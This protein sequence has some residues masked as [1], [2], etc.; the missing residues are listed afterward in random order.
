MAT[1]PD[2]S[3]TNSS[4]SSTLN[5]EIKRGRFSDSQVIFKYLK[6]SDSSRLATFKYEAEVL[7]EL[8]DSNLFPKFIS[9]EEQDGMPCL[10]M[11]DIFAESLRSIVDS[12]RL[13]LEAAI[14]AGWQTAL[15][16]GEL[17][18]RK[19]VHKDINPSNIIANFKER[20]VQVIDFG[21]STKV[22]KTEDY[23]DLSEEFA[24]TISY[25]SPEQTGRVNSRV[26]Y[27]SDF[28][29]LGVTLYELLTGTLPFDGENHSKTIYKII[30][31]SPKPPR[32]INPSIP[33][34][35]SELVM[36]LLE[37]D[38]D[39]RYQTAAGIA[40]DLE[41]IHQSI[42][43]G[44][45]LSS[46]CLKMKD[47]Q[48]KFVYP[49]KLYGREKEIGIIKEEFQ[50][51]CNGE[52]SLVQ[53]AGHSGIG[54]SAIVDYLKPMIFRSNCHFGRGKF[55]QYKKNIP[56][57][58]LAESMI[59]VIHG[60]LKGNKEYYSVVKAQLKSMSR[61]NSTIL[62]DVI[63]DFS[64]LLDDELE[65]VEL[66]FDFTEYSERLKFA[67]NQFLKILCDGNTPVVL[68]IDDVQ[69]ADSGSLELM[70]S[71]IQ[72]DS[73]GSLLVI[74]AY[75][76]NEMYPSHK[77]AMSINVLEKK[78]SDKI[79][80]L[81][82]EGISQTA[83]GDLVADVLHCD[84]S[85]V[86]GMSKIIHQKTGGNP[87]YIKTL[88]EYLHDEAIF[89]F[90]YSEQKWEWDF[91]DVENAQ[92]TDNV[93]DLLL[94][95][96]KG[97]TVETQSLLK[98]ASCMG[99]KFDY[100]TLSILSGLSDQQLYQNL[101]PAL[102]GGM[103]YPLDGEF[104]VFLNDDFRKD[105][106]FKFRFAHDKVQQASYELVD[107][108]ERQNYHYIIAK[109]LLSSFEGDEI[110]DYIF[111]IAGHLN[112]GSVHF[113]SDDFLEAV[114]LNYKA[115]EIAF[116][117][118]S[119][120]SSEHY[121]SKAKEYLPSISEKERK[122]ELEFEISKLLISCQYSN[123][124]YDNCI[125]NIS[126]L[127]SKCPNNV[128]LADLLNIEGK[129]YYDTFD[130]RKALDLFV[131]A[132]NT[133]G[134]KVT[135][136]VNK[137][138][139]LVHSS[140]LLFLSGNKFISWY[141][142]S[143]DE[144]DQS[145]LETADDEW[146]LI[147]K[148]FSRVMAASYNCD[149]DTMPGLLYSV[150]SI[151][152][153][154]GR[155][156]SDP[157]FGSWL[158]LCMVVFKKADAAKRF[159]KATIKLSKKIGP[160]P[161]DPMTGLVLGHFCAG[162]G[163]DHEGAI[164]HLEKGYQR[165]LETG[166][167]GDSGMCAALSLANTWFGGY[168][169]SQIIERRDRFYDWISPH[170]DQYFWQFFMSNNQ[171]IELLQGNTE[172]IRS[173]STTELDDNYLKE[174]SIKQGKVW[175][176]TYG[177]MRSIAHFM[178]GNYDLSDQSLTMLP[179]LDCPATPQ[180]QNC[181]TAR[182]IT[183]YKIAKSRKKK[184]LS[185]LN[186]FLIQVFS[187]S[188]RWLDKNSRLH[189]GNA[190]LIK[191]EQKYFK[192]K[193]EESSYLLEK[194]L[195]QFLEH[196][197][198]FWAAYT[199]EALY[200]NSRELGLAKASQ[201]YLEQAVSAYKR[202]GSELILERFLERYKLSSD[203][204]NESKALTGDVA[205]QTLTAGTTS[206]INK[207]FL[208]IDTENLI[209]ASQK[210]AG[211]MDVNE[212]AKEMIELVMRN[213]GADVGALAFVD[214]GT[215]QIQ[216]ITVTENDDY[217][218]F[219][220]P[221]S[222]GK[223]ALVAHEIIEYVLHTKEFLVINSKEQ[224]LNEFP[225]CD[226]SDQ[227]DVGSMLS[228][229]I[230]SQ[231]KVI[232][233]LFLRN[234]GLENAF[235]QE[236]IQPLKI[237]ASQCAVSL[238]N[239]QYVAKITDASQ[240]VSALKGQLE[241]ILEGTKEMS[242]KNKIDDA[243]AI[244]VKTIGNEVSKLKRSRFAVVLRSHDEGGKTDKYTYLPLLK[245]GRIDR[246][247]EDYESTSLSDK[248]EGFLGNS[249]INRVD[250]DTLTSVIAWQDEV[251]GMLILEGISGVELSSEDG[252]FIET[253]LQSLA[254]SLRNIEH[255]EHLENL[256]EAR[257][258]ALNEALD[259]IT[260]RQRKIQA[261]LDHIDEGILTLDANLN[262]EDE[263]SKQLENILG[264]SRQNITG[265][266][267]LE[268]CL[269]NSNL[270][271]IDI[272][273][274]TESLSTSI[275][276]ESFNW[277]LN[278]GHLPS[279]AL[280][281]VGTES[282]VLTF[283]WNPMFNESGVVEKVVLAIRDVTS[284]REAEKAQV[285]LEERQKHRT[286]ILTEMLAVERGRLNLFVDD[287]GTRLEKISQ[288]DKQEEFFSDIFIELHTI[289]GAS[290]ALD[291]S[292]F[293]DLTHRVEELIPTSRNKQLNFNLEDFNSQF[294]EL[295]TEYSMMGE[296]YSEIFE[297][298]AENTSVGSLHALVGSYVEG[299]QSRIRKCGLSYTSIRINDGIGEW[300]SEKIKVLSSVLPHI[301][302]NAIDHG[303]ILPRKRGVTVGGVEIE[304]NAQTVDGVEKLIIS[305]TGAGINHS[306]LKKIAKDTGLNK[307]EYLEVIFA[308]GTSTA[309]EVTLTSG[310]GVGMG[311]VRKI[312]RQVGGDVY[313]TDGDAKGTKCIINMNI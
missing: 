48:D 269:N 34:Q 18:K 291:F 231:A 148:I 40:H 199:F 78:Y 87:F 19:I 271:A 200:R 160:M 55:D 113:E 175:R 274:V 119:F 111:E 25:I 68:F 187:F 44:S 220:P 277:M 167:V 118:A 309:D 83:L 103:I 244:A 308:D 64:L 214:Q 32:I 217:N 28:F 212:L 151:A 125:K 299:L 292:T 134:V 162:L 304:V 164:T 123:K 198:Y 273:R 102:N 6:S 222:S 253:L 60:I 17:A 158:A 258:I 188:V 141:E 39:N 216:T 137:L 22:S 254:L 278:S 109:N 207:A 252:Q 84:T 29:S 196:R 197:K 241:K 88:L 283:H 99:S 171:M 67:F 203:F 205:R 225:H 97:L 268:V 89:T 126:I 276:E 190:N 110:D 90:N 186:Y 156:L 289:K 112:I 249:G 26:D 108:A 256:V 247:S 146:N 264:L 69:W 93:V 300:N 100:K 82:I 180:W 46:F 290:S 179:E 239:A 132:L 182:I 280:V 135:G 15:A 208:N 174:L 209:E 267:I 282:K 235:T 54:K 176:A 194:S 275:G 243:L 224:F 31:Q 288:I 218:V 181:Y 136:R 293:A 116:K 270:S 61:E 138:T 96:L 86:D 155:R 43:D 130:F 42:K 139:M 73:I 150:C 36:I 10:I 120:E 37:K 70:N 144:M 185:P 191:A 161:S 246:G 77:Y 311:A 211:Q 41:M 285:E 142:T 106:N 263:F 236:R 307:D 232:A 310:R 76:S 30:T 260:I 133:L 27:R 66:K 287:V 261:I 202:F 95:K 52:K 230:I 45:S 13:P 206:T 121:L 2:L 20:R 143:V 63:P 128:E 284:Q 24:G 170:T 152:Y 173:L 16:L 65:K 312:I 272:N 159:K 279:E 101:W 124:H 281:T 117:T 168:D 62:A 9:L 94:S 303:Y 75:R 56:Y 107:D 298:V 58:A 91:S 80:L 115:G 219:F 98:S 1:A 38:P 169:L 301:L 8:G 296:I 85:L 248:W 3:N 294:G 215:V 7:R 257:T 12:G 153:R 92:I 23:I 5:S 228:I 47:V 193:L 11:E 227:G 127:K 184:W 131:L 147:T 295:Q 255:Q 163:D 51:I 233:V 57:Y 178:V 165:G 81:N 59:D 210:I 183:K 286:R 237:L 140:Q 79:K 259:E 313:L 297:K 71:F 195:E 192:G 245:D 145:K 172:N 21:I 189:S 14:F 157:G 35:L 204:V 251:I 226:F 306:A 266:S 250:E 221:F 229:P 33:E 129:V 122:K 242:S 50:N 49:E 114:K 305:D 177:M 201:F 74:T 149:A 265:R 234:R 154:K 4:I 302:N 262:I 72:N 166:N 104:L 53:I 213:A 105:S 240:V 238:S 223:E